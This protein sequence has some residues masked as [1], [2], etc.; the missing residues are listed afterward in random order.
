VS[1]KDYGHRSAHILNLWGFMW[2]LILLVSYNGY[3]A[4]T[5]VEFKNEFN[6]YQAAKKV[7]QDFRVRAW[8]CV[9]K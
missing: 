9:P 2:I 7:Q 1:E 6:C 5:S 3:A 8:S 4:M